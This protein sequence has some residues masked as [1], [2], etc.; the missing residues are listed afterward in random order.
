MIIVVTIYPKIAP[1]KLKTAFDISYFISMGDK[2]GHIACVFS[3]FLI[4]KLF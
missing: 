4:L 1:R 2:D 3:F